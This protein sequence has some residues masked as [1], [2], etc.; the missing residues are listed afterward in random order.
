MYFGCPLYDGGLFSLLSF[1]S[2]YTRKAAAKTYPQIAMA[3]YPNIKKILADQRLAPSKKL[4]QNF[5]VH[6]QTAERIITAAPVTGGDTV[7]ELGVGL[8]SLTL[9]LANT[10]DR[11]IGIEIDQG[12]VDFHNQEQDLPENVE[13]IHQDLLKTDFSDLG[14]TLGT[15]LKIMANLPYS[16][17]N[18]LLFKLYRSRNHVEWAV[19]MLQKEVGDR[20]V[21]QPG[22]KEYGVLTVLLA[23]C[24]TVKRLLKIGPGHFHPK[25][26][27][28]SVVVEIRFHPQPERVRN[29]PAYDASIFEAIVNR[30][31]QQRRKTLVNSLAASGIGKLSKKQFAE[32][33]KNEKLPADIR[34]ERL[35]AEDFVRLAR[36][37]EKQL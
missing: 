35:T 21:A 25:P 33:L 4:G 34:A 11:I 32:I 13:L 14:K 20:L 7:V 24:A 29:L 17:S 9:P 6:R 16:V 31:F 18:P 8:G 15:R 37:I 10:V 26:K 30:A 27:V 23:S 12:I 1:L 22:T 2:E 3:T 5:L 28:E 19:L 36:T